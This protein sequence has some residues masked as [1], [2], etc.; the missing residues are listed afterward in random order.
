MFLF[1]LWTNNH[2]NKPNSRIKIAK[3]QINSQDP[4]FNAILDQRYQMGSVFNAQNFNGRVMIKPR[5]LK[6]NVEELK[7]F[8]VI[9]HVLNALITR[10]KAQI[11][12]DV[13]NLNVI[14]D[15][16]C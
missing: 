15:R 14:F 4:T 8:W 13:F 7:S 12:K 1:I 9:V 11:R 6:L 16:N 10:C 2:R 3:I 5:A